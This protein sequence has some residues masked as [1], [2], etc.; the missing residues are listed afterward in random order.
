MLGTLAYMAPEQSEGHDVGEP[1]DLYSLALVLYEAFS[2]EN[3]VRGETPAATAR[4]IGRPVPSLA[5]RRPDLPRELCEDIDW[6]LLPDFRERATLPDLRAGLE[7]ALAQGLPAEPLPREATQ[8]ARTRLFLRRPAR[9]AAA[10]PVHPPSAAS[11]PRADLGP[12]LAPGIDP[13]DVEALEGVRSRRHPLER[14]ALP[15]VLW[16]AAALALAT[17]EAASGWPGLA[18]LVLALAAPL[19]VLGRRPPLAWLLAA[20]APLL[21]LLGLAGA[22]PALA[23][24]APGWRARATL[25]ALGYWWLVLAGAL[26]AAP[27]SASR[28]WLAPP[29]P[30]PA[31]F[32]WE[33]SLTS[34][35]SHV[36][37]PVLTLGL[38]L[39]AALWGARGG[40]PA[41]ARARS[42]RAAGCAR[43]D[44][45]VGRAAGR[46]P[47][48]RVGPRCSR[49]AARAPRR[50]A[51]DDPRR[52]HRGR[53]ACPARSG[54]KSERRRT[55][56]KTPAQRPKR[57][58]PPTQSRSRVLAPM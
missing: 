31:R 2:G 42:Q 56:P 22:Y 3:P 6:A 37:A 52:R 17:W 55:S 33:A 5:V 29:T 9:T 54:L 8:T 14:L 24:Q 10:R 15:R 30:P 20:L 25:G 12:A 11:P 45:L 46:D 47:A 18:L 19:L 40:A 43:G 7:Q 16:L 28:L 49:P 50:R 48:A 21:G 57:T 23:G 27:S 34:A 32:V 41:V 35:A 1:A 4:R 39:G 13:G 44:R 58:S 51:R 36:L 38:L 53:R 26:L